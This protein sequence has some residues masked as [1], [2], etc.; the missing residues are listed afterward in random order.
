MGLNCFIPAANAAALIALY[1]LAAR[2][3]NLPNGF[4]SISIFAGSSPGVTWFNV[5][6]NTS[7]FTAGTTTRLGGWGAISWVC[8]FAFK[9]VG[10][11]KAAKCAGHKHGKSR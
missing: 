7:F 10:C 6:G 5:A 3:C 1:A 9:A 2:G 8:R 4:I 11:N